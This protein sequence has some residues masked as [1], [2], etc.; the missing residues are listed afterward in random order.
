MQAAGR[1][2]LSARERAVAI[3]SLI[4]ATASQSAEAALAKAQYD[5][6]AFRRVGGRVGRI[7]LGARGGRARREATGLGVMPGGGRMWATT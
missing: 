3:R 5:V 2:R 1:A 6:E 4:V 7:G